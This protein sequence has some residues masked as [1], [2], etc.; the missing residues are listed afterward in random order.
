MELALH[1]L[2][3]HEGER[4][5]ILGD[6]F[7]MGEYEAT[8]HQRIAQLALDL[9]IEEIVLVGKAFGRV[10]GDFTAT[11]ETTD[12]LLEYLKDHQPKG[13]HI[14]I[15]GSRGMTLEKAIELL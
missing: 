11:V 4:M 6:M 2:A 8:E 12:E 1:S 10:D 13:K 3:K 7:E 5:A 15:K 14:L 9:E